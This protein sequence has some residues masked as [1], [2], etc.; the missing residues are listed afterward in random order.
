MV[1]VATRTSFFVI[2]V[3]F[4]HGLQLVFAK[5]GCRTTDLPYNV[6]CPAQHQCQAEERNETVAQSL[7]A[8]GGALGL[9]K[10]KTEELSSHGDSHYGREALAEC[11]YER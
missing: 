11:A 3:V 8:C 10:R 7:K 2:V 4:V 9:A 1:V 5:V 6:T